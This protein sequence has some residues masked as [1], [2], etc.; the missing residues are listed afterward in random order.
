MLLRLF[1]SDTYASKKMVIIIYSN[2]LDF[3]MRRLIR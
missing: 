3:V 1:G 2:A